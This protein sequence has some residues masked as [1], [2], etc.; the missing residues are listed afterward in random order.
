M[1]WTKIDDQFYDHPKVVAAG[2]LGVALFVST[3]QVA[4]GG[5]RV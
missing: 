2:P 4:M 5:E 3:V 1:P